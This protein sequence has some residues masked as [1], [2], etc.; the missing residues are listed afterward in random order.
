M[1]IGSEFNIRFDENLIRR[2]LTPAQEALAIARRKVIYETLYPETKHGGNK[3]PCAQF[4]HTDRDSFSDAT[5]NATG[6]DASTIRRA[7]ARGEALGDDL[8][9]IAG[10]SL[11]KGVELDAL[12]K[13]PADD[14]GSSCFPC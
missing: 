3:G 10:T 9:S 6:K 8:D 11:D 13:M 4:A 14:T 12:V 2:N 7:A 1:A 5:A